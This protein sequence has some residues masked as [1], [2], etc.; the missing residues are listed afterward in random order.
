M[1]SLD[2][3]IVANAL[4][5]GV[6][7]LVKAFPLARVATSFSCDGH[8][9]QP[10]VV[11]FAFPWDVAWG[12]AVF[13]HL[14]VVP[15]SSRWQWGDRW[16]VSISPV[17]GYHYDAVRGM[18]EDIQNFARRLL[19]GDTIIKVGEARQA[20]LA[21]FARRRVPPSIEEFSKVTGQVL[22]NGGIDSLI[23]MQWQT[24]E[25]AR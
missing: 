6:A 10:A 4:D 19:D 25:L 21:Y 18:L 12:K 5:I 22:Q 7:L 8:G 11:H 20:T 17:N 9:E 13:D 1:E 3:K 23:K 15:T 16:S 2:E 14:S 24:S